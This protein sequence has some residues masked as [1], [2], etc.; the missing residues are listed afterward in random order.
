MRIGRVGTVVAMVTTG[1]MA[2]SPVRAAPAS[3]HPSQARPTASHETTRR[4]HKTPRPS[5]CSGEHASQSVTGVNGGLTVTFT[6]SEDASTV[7]FDIA[8]SETRAYGALGP[9]VLSFGDGT[10]EGFGTPEYCLVNP[11]AETND[12]QI[13]YTYNAAGTYT[14][15]VTVGANCTPDQLTLT[16]V[17][18]VG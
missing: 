5:V 14:T 10:S 2:V 12:R 9:E 3:A 16:L 1:L 15:S 18:N 11:V 7:T 4:C 8:S 6:A 13:S 17:I